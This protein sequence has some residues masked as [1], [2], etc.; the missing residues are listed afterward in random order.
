MVFLNFKCMIKT[1]S[2]WNSFALSLFPFRDFSVV[3]GG[4]LD[5]RCCKLWMVPDSGVDHLTE[6]YEIMSRCIG[7][8]SLAEDP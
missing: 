1:I 4:F 5:E 8:E 3:T 7:S 2:W 6:G